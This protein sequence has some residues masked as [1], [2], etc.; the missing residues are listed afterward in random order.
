MAT[1]K[2]Y[3]ATTADA[4]L[5]EVREK[6]DGMTSAE[7]QQVINDAMH[8]LENEEERR[9]FYNHIMQNLNKVLHQEFEDALQTLTDK[10]DRLLHYGTY[11]F[12][13]MSRDFE[14]N[15]I[16]FAVMKVGDHRLV[17]QSSKS[18]LR[19][20]T[21]VEI[22]LPGNPVNQDMLNAWDRQTIQ[23]DIDYH[24]KELDKLNKLKEELSSKA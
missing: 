2:T 11:T 23:S 10:L 19:D 5:A 6:I 4:M 17:L 12:E 14:T 9:K 24:Q 3:K 18:T 21:T 20:G 13:R 8:S 16:S 15:R 7:A 22:T 1:K